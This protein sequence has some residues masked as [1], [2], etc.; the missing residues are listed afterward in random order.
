MNKES[1]TQTT[2]QAEWLSLIERRINGLRFGAI[3]IVI[4][5]GKVTQVE[6]TE[7]TRFAQNQSRT[8]ESVSAG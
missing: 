2:G 4:H 1:Y 6:I 5:E 8:G 7:K 3:Q